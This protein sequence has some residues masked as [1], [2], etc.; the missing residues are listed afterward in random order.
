MFITI[1]F[2]IITLIFLALTVYFLKKTKNVL[3]KNHETVNYSQ[4]RSTILEWILI[5][6]RKY[7]SFINKIEIYLRSVFDQPMFGKINFKSSLFKQLTSIDSFLLIHLCESIFVNPFLI[8][9]CFFQV[10]A[11]ELTSSQ[12]GRGRGV[13]PLTALM[14]HSCISNAR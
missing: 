8:Q 5:K 11:F 4:I 12:G 10:N 14:S 7:K 13:F 6:Y 1:G 3:E 2:L 9:L